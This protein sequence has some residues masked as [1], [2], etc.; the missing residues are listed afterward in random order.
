MLP[1]STLQVAPAVRGETLGPSGGKF[2]PT[3]RSA[4]WSA[5]AAT[6]GLLFP[7][8]W[9]RINL[10]GHYHWRKDAGLRNRKLRRLRA[11]KLDLIP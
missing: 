10:T 9:E 5:F 7:S 4:L 3:R 11:S 8:K 1:P 6:G 2:C